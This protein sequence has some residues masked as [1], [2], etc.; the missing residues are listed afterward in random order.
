MAIG[1]AG[2]RPRIPYSI[3]SAPEETAH[4]G[5]LDF[6]VK[7]DGGERWGDEFDPL[8]RGSRVAVSGPSG[9]FVFPAEPGFRQLLFIAG[10][11]GIAP[12]RSMIRHAVLSHHPARMRLLYSARTP[13]DFAYLPELRGMARRREIE[14]QLTTTREGPA[15]WRGSRGRIVSAQLSPLVDDPDVLCFVCGPA[16]MVDDVPRMLEA[17]GVAKDRI[18]VDEW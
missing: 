2:A 6:L 8:R 1:P 12:F 18:L 3:A 5:G 7:V 15:T 9:N 13:D 11:S 17:L 10:G 4:H 14:L 16:A